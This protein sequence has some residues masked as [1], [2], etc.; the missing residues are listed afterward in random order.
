MTSASTGDCAFHCMEGFV[1]VEPVRNNSSAAGTMAHGLH[2][3]EM[4]KSGGWK[5]RT[6]LWTGAAL[7][8]KAPEGLLGLRL[9]HPN[10]YH[11]VASSRPLSSLRAF[12]S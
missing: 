5:T 9:L 6:E 7:L 3:P 12:L 8:T 11:H 4:Q 1:L 2:R 10:L